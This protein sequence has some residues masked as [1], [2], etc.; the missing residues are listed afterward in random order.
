MKGLKTE[1]LNNCLHLLEVQ[2]TK[3]FKATTHDL[4]TRAQP[5]KAYEKGARG[6]LV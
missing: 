2:F 6:F 3:S 5:G 1:E 4:S